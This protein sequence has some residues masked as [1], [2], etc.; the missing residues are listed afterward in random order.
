MRALANGPDSWIWWEWVGDHLD[1]IAA[2]TREHVLLTAVSVGIGLAISFPLALAVRRWP[3]LSLPV[4]WAAG[5]MYAVPSLALFG[6][7][8]PVTGL[9]RTTAVIPLVTYT[10]LILVRNIV[11]GLDGVPRDVRESAAG[12][13]YTGTGRF[14]RVDLPLAVPTILAGVRVATVSTIAL[15][16]VTAVIG[17]DSLGQLILDGLNR[18]FRTPLVVGIGLTVALAVTAE[19]ALLAVE[20][21]VTPWAR[22]RR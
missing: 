16:T 18:D 14:L 8:V 19:V 20:R 6:I 21:V 9:T 2:S 17:Q 4:L 1:D 3:S 13:G 5:A 7:L 10:L 22:G 12:M 15:V 11:A